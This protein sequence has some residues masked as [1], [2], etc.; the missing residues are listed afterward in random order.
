MR[1]GTALR[2]GVLRNGR[3]AE[4][5]VNSEKG[6]MKKKE[7]L[8]S[9]R[10]ESEELIHSLKT[11][12]FWKTILLMGIGMLFFAAAINGIIIPHEYMSGGISGISLIVYYLVGWPSVGII[13]FLINIPIFAIGWR[14]ISL[15]FIV[16][17][18]IGTVIFSFSLQF[19][20]GIRLPAHDNIMAAVL[21]GILM[22]IGTGLYIRVGGT[23][24]GLDIIATIAKKRLGIP[25]GRIF[26]M[27]NIVPLAAAAFINSLDVAL[28][29]GISMYVYSV[30]VDRVQTG[31]SQRQSVFII[32]SKPKE[33]AQGVMK[34]IDRGVTFLDSTGGYSKRKGYVLYTVINM[35]ELGRLKQLLFDIDPGAFVAINNTS[36]VIG[37]RF[38][39]WEDEGFTAKS[40]S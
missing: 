18:F 10:H 23:A 1:T 30:V 11:W 38:L 28:Y 37:R 22:G 34:R 27:L 29:S 15:R 25:M 31:F 35:K 3:K 14:E 40:H 24:G 39:S 20:S 2:K 9:F 19:T 16:L 17:S 32:S 8:N 4:Q 5:P 33:V 6:T 21:A 7:L 13:Y 12:R 26:F 36:E